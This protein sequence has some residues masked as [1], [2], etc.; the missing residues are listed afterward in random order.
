MQSPVALIITLLL[1]I[2]CMASVAV[3][4]DDAQDL[5]AYD[6]LT[7]DHKGESLAAVTL[8]RKPTPR[9]SFRPTT[10][11]PTTAKPSVK[12]V[13]L[14]CPVDCVV[15]S[16]PNGDY[17]SCSFFPS[18]PDGKTFVSGPGGFYCI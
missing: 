11:R 14:E 1:V 7:T 17:C 5:R 16:Y 6:P 4:K 13:A 2:S 18:C 15:V 10:G 3:G 8:T 9:P 12:P